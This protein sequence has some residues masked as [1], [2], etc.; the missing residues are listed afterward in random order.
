MGKEL[1]SLG[2]QKKDWMQEMNDV[3][4]TGFQK[5]MET[6]TPEFYCKF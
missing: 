1:A 2:E 3:M 5:I 4:T 6:A